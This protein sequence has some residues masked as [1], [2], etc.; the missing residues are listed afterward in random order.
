MKNTINLPV[1]FKLLT[2]LLIISNL[3]VFGLFTIIHPEFPWPDL[4]NSGAA[5][6]IQFFGIRHVAFGIIL[7]HG[8]L[9]KNIEVLK[10]SYILFLIISVLDVL[11]LAIY[12]YY[13]DP[14]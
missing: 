8:M 7:L 1:W 5:F 14:L 3:L 6:P 10:A 12:G 13:I 11:L 2:W 9:K 4:N